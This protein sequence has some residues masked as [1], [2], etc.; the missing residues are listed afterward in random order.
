M[1]THPSAP[2]PPGAR[3]FWVPDDLTFDTLPPALQGAIQ[4]IVDPAYT[5]LVLQAKTALEQSMGVSYVKLLWIE[6]ID[7]MDIAKDTARALSR[8][9]SPDG[10]QAKVGQHLRLIAQKGKIAKF[11]LEI[12]KVYKPPGGP[13]PLR[14]PAE[15][16]GNVEDQN[17][18]DEI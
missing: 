6:I 2:P 9:E 10:H 4:A 7:A 11:L 14:R 5:E 13:D 16:E 3:P 1:S 12:Q 8:G 17:L 18:L 15:G